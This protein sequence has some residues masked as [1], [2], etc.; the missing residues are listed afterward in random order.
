MINSDKEQQVKLQFLDEATDYLD[1]LESGLLGLGTGAVADKQLDGLL[2][3]AH[4]IKGGAAMMGYKTLAGLG[5]H[6]EDYFKI[7][8]YGKAA[9]PDAQIEQL[10]LATV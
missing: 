5:H 8:Q 9:A 1:T 2:R 6:L 10:M 3:A 4:S 7:I